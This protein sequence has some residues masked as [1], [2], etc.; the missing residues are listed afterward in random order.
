ML[1]L[2]ALVESQKK[3]MKRLG[4]I[5]VMAGGKEH[6]TFSITPLFE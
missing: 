3:T 4:R 6:S 1:A 2:R 5:K